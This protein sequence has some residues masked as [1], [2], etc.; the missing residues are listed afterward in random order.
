M[1]LIL[2]GGYKGIGEFYR[3]CAGLVIL[4]G[5]TFIEGI[6]VTG[7]SFASLAGHRTE[8]QTVCF[9]HLPGWQTYTVVF[10][11]FV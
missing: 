10:S 5:W 11:G 3:V 4:C 8:F 6:V 9:F 7:I 1:Q 2:L